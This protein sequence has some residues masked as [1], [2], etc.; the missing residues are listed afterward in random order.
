MDQECG[1][2]GRGLH[3]SVGDD[4]RGERD[5]E[6]DQRYCG[7]KPEQPD[8]DP[9]RPRR[10]F[11]AERRPESLANRGEGG[12]RHQ[13]EIERDL[14]RHQRHADALATWL[15]GAERA[16]ADVSIPTLVIAGSDDSLTPEANAEAI[17]ARI[18]R[19]RVERLEGIGH[20]PMIEDPERLQALLREFLGD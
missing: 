9:Q 4:E 5:V 2:H 20:A 6:S 1:R 8:E 11:A 3:C 10:R 7:G 17:A 15:E 19:A 16:Y 13:L 14:Q 18:P 12:A